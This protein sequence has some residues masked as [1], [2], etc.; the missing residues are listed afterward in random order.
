MQLLEARHL[1]HRRRPRWTLI[2]ALVGIAVVGAAGWKVWESTRPRYLRWKQ[3]RAL[4]Q[5][6]EFIEK[7]D[8]PN[9]K[10]AL[11]VALRTVPGNPDVLRTAADMLEQGGSPDA[12]RLRRA[13]VQ[14][15]PRSAEDAARLVMCCLRFRD[16]NAAKDALSS[17]PPDVSAEAPMLQA[18]LAFALA[19]DNT[20]VADALLTQLREVSPDSDNLIYSQALLRLRHPREAERATALRQLEELASRDPERALLV[21][22][23]LAA[24]ALQR[25]DYVELKKRQALILEHPGATFTDH[26]QKANV[27]L[28]V[29]KAEFDSL[30][31]RLAPLASSNDE[32]IT[33]FIQWL[34]VQDRANEADTWL[35]SLPAAQRDTPRVRAAQADIVAQIGDWD[36]LSSLLESEAW[37]PISRET[38]RLAFAARTVDSPA[39]PSLRKETWDLTLDSAVGNLSA[40]RVLQ[41]LATVWRWEDET[42]RTLWSVARTFP[43]QTWAHQTLFNLYRARRDIKGMRDVVAVLRQSEGSVRRYQ[44]DWALLTLLAEPTSNWNPAKDTMRALYEAEP[45]NATYGTGY[46]FALAQAGKAAE[47]LAIV[48]KMTEIERHYPPR[49]PFLAFV[50]GVAKK[51]AEVEQAAKLAENL[52]LLPEERYLFTRAREELNRKPPKPANADKAKSDPTADL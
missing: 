18:A 49:Q 30:F 8:A 17:T 19:T 27:D 1:N 41:R 11:D 38:L 24:D 32:D 39:R 43:A 2:I 3:Q 42:E 35:A 45:S 37:G 31:A 52:D 21:H 34:L 20:I 9:A 44:H 6:K 40:L 36:R 4:S 7:R 46:A 48:E 26:L 10:L 14:L 16:F 22:R 23:E 13:V 47:A 29:D 28:L 12:M 25:R 33:Q 50:Y 51:S 5:A 15:L